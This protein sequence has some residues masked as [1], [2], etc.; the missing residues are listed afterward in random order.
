MKAIEFIKKHGLDNRKVRQLIISNWFWV[1]STIL[2]LI[3]IV[4]AMYTCSIY[5]G[6]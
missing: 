1:T 3:S 6:Q 4:Y 5:Y 2:A